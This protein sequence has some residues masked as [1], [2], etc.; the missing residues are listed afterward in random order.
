MLSHLDMT[1]HQGERSL[2]LTPSDT[3]TADTGKRGVRGM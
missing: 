2:N 3:H 1:N